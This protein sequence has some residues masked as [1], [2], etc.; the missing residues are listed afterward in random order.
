M[1]GVDGERRWQQGETSF[2]GIDTI[3]YF[4]ASPSFHSTEQS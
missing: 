4:A 2:A 1:D 3:Y